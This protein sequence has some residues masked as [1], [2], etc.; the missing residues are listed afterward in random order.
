MPGFS[1]LFWSGIIQNYLD[2]H[3]TCF[4]QPHT[5]LLVLGYLTTRDA[6][7]LS[8]SP[9][10]VLQRLS[11]YFNCHDGW[12][13]WEFQSD[14]C[15]GTKLGTDLVGS[16]SKGTTQYRNEHS[17]ALTRLVSCSQTFKKGCSSLWVHLLN[18][19]NI[20]AMYTKFPHFFYTR[21]YLAYMLRLHQQSIPLSQGKSTYIQKSPRPR[22]QWHLFWTV[23]SRIPRQHGQR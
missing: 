6:I 7:Q 17:S 22:Q 11:S 9:S 21:K 1:C 23:T 13:R 18:I 19:C 20:P 10:N 16:C 14:I 15:G 2:C 3:Y 12:D 8:L 5:M 4:F